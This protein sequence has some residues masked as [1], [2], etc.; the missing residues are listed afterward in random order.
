MTSFIF[1]RGETI[2]LALDAVQGDVAAVSTLSAALKPVAAGRTSVDPASPV[3]ATFSVA[4][5]AANGDNPAGWTL[6]ISA[7]ASAGLIAGSYL[8]DA[9]LTAGGGVT[10]TTPLAIRINDPVTP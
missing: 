4:S 10:V 5:R 6:T 9:K 8:A 3:A 2:A 1:Q 7:A